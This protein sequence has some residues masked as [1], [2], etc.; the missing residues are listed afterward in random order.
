MTLSR[1]FYNVDFKEHVSLPKN[2]EN[3]DDFMVEMTDEQNY[4]LEAQ[5]RRI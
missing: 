3:N 1:R 5:K 4:H 2:N